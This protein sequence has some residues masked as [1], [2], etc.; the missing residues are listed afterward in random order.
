VL[1]ALF[2]CDP[3]PPEGCAF[4]SMATAPESASTCPADAGDYDP[5]AMGPAPLVVMFTV[6]TLNRAYL[7]GRHPE[8][9]ITPRLDAFFAESAYLPGVVSVRSLT[10]VAL[11]SLLTGRY[12]RAHGV[13]DHADQVG[14]AIETLPEHLASGGYATRAFISNQC[15]VIDGKVDELTCR[16]NRQD[17]SDQ[18]L[19][20][21]ELVTSFTRALD[22]L[23]GPTFLWIH[24]VDPHTPYDAREPYY[25]TFHPEPPAGDFDPG[26]EGALAD[27]NLGQ[28]S[29]TP[30]EHAQVEAAY[31]SQVAL[32]DAQFGEV[33]DA[34]SSRGLD[35]AI[36]V[37]GADHGEEL[38]LHSHYY[39][40]SC[41]TFN[42]SLMLSFAIRAP[43]RLAGGAV[44]ASPVSSTDIAPTVAELAGL[45]WDNDID[46]TSLVGDFRACREP[47]RP[48]YF[49]RATEAA[50][51]VV[52]GHKL[53]LEPEGWTSAC[54]PYTD[55]IPY[56]MASEQLYDIESDPDE[57]T[58]LAEDEP[59][60]FSDLRGQLC[61]WVLAAPWVAT[62]NERNPVV[63]ACGG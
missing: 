9:D 32:I 52:G 28:R 24:L 8:W 53:V 36:V 17:E 20:D 40:H 59:E 13:R 31:A 1:F 37:F 46:G 4:S 61:D 23:S 55:D 10:G 5:A 54:E 39:W 45:P 50:G 16:W 51:M 25:D 34:L 3:E 15:W 14:T 44:M 60:M 27:V 47:T 42:A 30:E 33:L 12:P 62:N 49:E 58:N 2:A 7:D 41:S 48:A 43:G 22:E 56:V 11:S 19:K 35:D 26:V 29:I 38:G 21:D 6:D 18:D 57:C 63:R